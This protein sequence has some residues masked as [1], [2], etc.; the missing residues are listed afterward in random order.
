M[1]YFAV[2]NLALTRP[3]RKLYDDYLSSQSQA[4]ESLDA[5]SIADVLQRLRRI[6]NHP[7]LLL[8]NPL[9]LEQVPDDD[10]LST[11]NFPRV[12]DRIHLPSRVFTAADYDPYAD[13]DLK[14]LNLVFFAHES[15]LTAITSD[16]IRKCCAP[17]VL[18]GKR[19]F[20]F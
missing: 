7:Q 15:T 1:F 4:L 5:Q 18:I 13:I 2:F 10:Q 9:M 8:E 11:L 17:K 6:C 12:M 19:K 20:A 14:S 3:Q 16:R